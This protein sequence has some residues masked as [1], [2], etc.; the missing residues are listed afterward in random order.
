MLAHSRGGKFERP[1]DATGFKVSGRRDL[2]FGGAPLP[3]AGA[4]DASR[5]S[6]L[7]NGRVRAGGDH[8][9]DEGPAM[10]GIVL[11]DNSKPVARRQGVSGDLPQPQTGGRSAG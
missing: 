8:S 3:G 5:N 6:A 7:Q 1:I 2:E 10:A 11:E 9:E 4:R